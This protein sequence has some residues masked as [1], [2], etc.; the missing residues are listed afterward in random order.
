MSA[1]TQI[2]PP[3]PK[4]APRSLDYMDGLRGLLMTLVLLLHIF[5]VTAASKGQL[6]WYN[7]TAL[8]FQPGVYTVG[9]F[10]VISGY[11]LMLP[12]ALS[13]SGALKGGIRGY[14]KRRFTRIIPPYYAAAALSA[15]HVIRFPQQYAHYGIATNAA[16]PAV[17]WSHALL[18]Y[19]FRQA[20]RFQIN[21]P[22]WSLA[23][24]WQIYILFPILL[25]PI[26]RKFGVGGLLAAGL[27]ITGGL[28]LTANGALQ[29]HP[30]FLFLFVSG[31]AG[32][33]I[34]NSNDSLHSRLR[35][36]VPW[37]CVSY[38][39]FG[40]FVLEWFALAFLRPVLLSLLPPAWQQYCI[41]ETTL[42]L[43]ILAAILHWD[44]IRRTQPPN[45][46]PAVFRLLN[47][48]WVTALGRF[49]YSHY[50]VHFP[51]LIAIASVIR[52]LRLPQWKALTLA[53]LVSVPVSLCGGYLFYLAVERR[54]L[55]SYRKPA[56]V[57]RPAAHISAMSG[58]KIGR[59]PWSPASLSSAGA[60][61]PTNGE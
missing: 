44:K 51:I 7:W 54:F 25:V 59:T 24:E 38:I 17:L 10:V 23:P 41:N 28:M 34:A 40:A 3:A 13:N 53:Y 39:L 16:Q 9:L 1:P 31:M 15:L 32:A 56:G 8:W 33:V 57:S 12:V 26:W 21:P 43:A 52:P 48:R 20:W 47:H 46:W 49:S 2:R 42:G 60:S 6:P 5:Y 55:P 30:W 18:F 50:L 37:A 36:R 35:E 45:R 22:Y 58:C 14:L 29:M 4:T 11:C 19:N 27:T 61:H